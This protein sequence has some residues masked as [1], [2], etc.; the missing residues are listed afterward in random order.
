MDPGKAIYRPV[1]HRT[2]LH[3]GGYRLF[4]FPLSLFSA[5]KVSW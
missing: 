2:L 5:T 3:F 1:E 4:N